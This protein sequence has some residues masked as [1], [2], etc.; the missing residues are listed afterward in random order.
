VRPTIGMPPIVTL[1]T[2][3]GV[4]PAAGG[5]TASDHAAITAATITS[6]V[7]VLAPP[8]IP[9]PRKTLAMTVA[10]PRWEEKMRTT[11]SFV[12]Q[13]RSS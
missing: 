2:A 4:A 9:S 3:G 1:V 6:H 7:A 8:V 5:G 10:R 11:L 12:K 13:W